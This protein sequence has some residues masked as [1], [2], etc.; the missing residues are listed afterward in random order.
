MRIAVLVQGSPRFCR[1]FDHLLSALGSTHEFDWYFWMWN[2]NPAPDVYGYTVVA[3]AWRDYTA[4][5]ARSKISGLLPAGHRVGR[6]ELADQSALKFDTDIRNKAGETNVENVWKMWH[7]LKQA[8]ELCLGSGR[9]YDLVMRVRPD[10]SM[11]FIDLDLIHSQLQAQPG[12][13]ISAN[14]HYGYW[15]TRLNDWTA[16]GLPREMAGYCSI[17]DHVS[18][19]H[20][21]GMI[22]HPESMLSYHLHRLQTPIIYGAYN[23]GIR[24]LGKLDGG[25]YTS[26]FGRWA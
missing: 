14:N 2:R 24:H 11:D 6:L 13:V 22:F 19:Y 23:V 1:E 9:S 18:Q 20:R 7:S 17:V 5:W 25:H 15:G 12:V 16:I 10:V 3:D 21:E 26:D 8:H 4:D